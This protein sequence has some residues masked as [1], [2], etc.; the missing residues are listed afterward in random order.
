MKKHAWWKQPSLTFVLMGGSAKGEE[1]LFC[2]TNY[3]E[4]LTNFFPK[5]KFKFI[6]VGPE[7]STVRN[8]KTEKKNPRLSATFFKTTVG[9]FLL[10]NFDSA[11]DIKMRLE[12]ASTIFIGFN[13]GFGCGYEELLHSWLKDQIMLFNLGYPVVYT[14]ANDYSDLWGE[15]KVF[16]KVFQNRVNYFMEP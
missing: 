6:F 7:L 1:R 13:P 3:F 12:P 16:E 15:T 8:N 11:V 2:Q 5:T 9:D 4:E 10:D 14:Q